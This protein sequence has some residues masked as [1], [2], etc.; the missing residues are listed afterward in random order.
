M[1]RRFNATAAFAVL[2]G[3]TALLTACASAP[4]RFFTLDPVVPI[5]ASAPAGGNYPGPP[6][7]IVAV[8]IPPSLDRTE[9]VE[10]SSPGE[11]KVNDFEH[12]E[13]P[14]GLVARQALTQDLVSRLP[15]GGILGP[16]TPG[17]LN[18]GTLS[19]DIVSFQ[20]T[21]AGATMQVTWSIS[22]PAQAGLSGPIVW[23]APLEQLQAQTSGTGGAAT[24][25]AFSAL[26]GQLADRITADLATKAPR[27]IPLNY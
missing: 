9:L 1:T 6:L 24:A 13:A 8:N 7:K 17:G 25:G 22:L 10:E 2:G 15:A 19:V 18:V 12:W 16:N 4:T 21:T 27:R 26:L 5:A 23:R 14:L 3:M 11:M 20:A